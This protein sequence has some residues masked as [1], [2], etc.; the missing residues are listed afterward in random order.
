MKRPQP[1]RGAEGRRAAILTAVAARPGCSY[2]ELHRVT[3]IA[4]RTLTHHIWMLRRMGLLQIAL[5]PGRNR[6][7]PAGR[8][9]PSFGQDLLERRP[10]LRMLLDWLT[11]QPLMPQKCVLEHTSQAWGWKESTTQQRLDR[12]VAVQLL[13]RRTIGL[14]GITYV[15][16][17]P[18]TLPLAM[19]IPISAEAMV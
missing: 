1:H 16:V 10:E 2:R 4:G 14:R 19:R 12:L 18:P 8:P 7:Y 6:H 13:E 9:V 5:A 17:R 11:S 3:G 15:P